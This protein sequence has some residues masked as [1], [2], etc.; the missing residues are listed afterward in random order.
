MIK[1]LELT[2]PEETQFR[3]AKIISTLVNEGDVVIAGDAL[4]KVKSGEQEIDLPARLG[5]KIIEMIVE[6]G[7]NISI[8]TPLVLLETEVE[9]STAD[10]VKKETP[11][12]PSAKPKKKQKKKPS[13]KENKRAN[14]KNATENSDPKLSQ[15]SLDLNGKKQAV[16]KLIESTTNEQSLPISNESSNMS[17]AKIGVPDIGIESAKVIEILVE[18][19]DE[20]SIDDALITLESDKASMD[21]PATHAGVIETIEVKIDQDVGEGDVIVTMTAAQTA[22]EKDTEAELKPAEKSTAEPSSSATSARELVNVT[23][24]DIGGDSATVIEILVNEGQQIQIEDPLVTLESDK[25]SMDVPSSA[26]GTIESVEVK[27][28]QEVEEGTVVIRV[29]SGAPVAVG[30]LIAEEEQQDSRKAEIKRLGKT[31]EPSTQLGNDD[32]AEAEP[33]PSPEPTSPSDVHASPSVRR[34]A[35]EL[36]A[37]LGRV[38]GSG[39]KG[40][41]TKDDVKQFVK[42]KLSARQSGAVDEGESGIPSIPAVDFSK[43]GEIEIQPLN[44]IKK[45]T[46]KNLHRSWLNVPHV[47]HK[48]ESNISNLEEFRKQL[49]QE[50]KSQGDSIKLSPLAFVVKAVVNALQVYPQFNASLEPGG[51]NLIYK[52]YFNIGIAV[53]TPN[54]LMV[55]VLKYADTKSVAEIAT[56]MGTLAAKARDKK[57]TPADMSG[58]CFTISSLGGI[59]GTGFTPIVNAPEVAILGVAR[60][61]MQPVWNGQ[62]FQPGM[63]LPLSLSY[64]HRVIDGAEA[65]RFTRQIAAVLEDVR[66]LAV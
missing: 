2:P 53:D 10:L 43:F 40:R 29:A 60:S 56:E 26:A 14:S 44:K 50:Y 38:S 35:R 39:R 64:D 47:T 59:G 15:Q 62:D 11:S 48:D 28:D 57:L 23:I 45:L 46:A 51:E 12:K 21:V 22:V 27:I 16:N 36:G 25:A 30:N 54:G 32:N 17:A 20:V 6:E 13:K 7:E 4:F 3:Q 55:P 1:Y 58:A 31:T 34:F 8:M 42:G 37:D 65:A 9:K 41:I 52:K 24:P 63:I 5:G 49:N 19:G 61:K 66:R 18:V 33:R